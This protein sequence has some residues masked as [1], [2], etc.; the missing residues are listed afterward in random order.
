MRLPL[1]IDEQELNNQ[2]K[3]ELES[4]KEKV[5]QFRD[6]R[7]RRI[8][9]R[10]LDLVFDEQASPLPSVGRQHLE[11]VLQAI[12]HVMNLIEDKY[13]GASTRFD[14]VVSHSGARSMLFYLKK[15]LMCKE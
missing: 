2:V 3:R 4:L 12:M 9:H 5:Q 11:E 14:V 6:W 8:A 13:V 7:N 15:G 1:L 10:D